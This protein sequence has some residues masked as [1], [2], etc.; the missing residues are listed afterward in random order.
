MKVKA[1]TERGGGGACLPWKLNLRTTTHN[2]QDNFSL[3]SIPSTD[4]HLSRFLFS[5][6]QLHLRLQKVKKER[7]R[8]TSPAAQKSASP[9]LPSFPLSHP[10]PSPPKTQTPTSRATK[11]KPHCAIPTFFPKSGFPLEEPQT[12]RTMAPWSNFSGDLGIRRF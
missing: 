10:T 6:T 7:C 9:S 3:F 2:T 12:R 8:N 5:P 1:S 4:I 11:P